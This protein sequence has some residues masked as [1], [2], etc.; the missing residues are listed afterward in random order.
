MTPVSSTVLESPVSTK[1]VK[2]RFAQRAASFSTQSFEKGSS[3]RV[4]RFMVFENQFSPESGESQVC[5]PRR[6]VYLSAM[7]TAAT[8]AEY[9]SRMRDRCLPGRQAVECGSAWSALTRQLPN[10]RKL[11]ERRVTHDR[12]RRAAILVRAPGRR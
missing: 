2:S 5:S 1:F 6:T 10:V 9:V 12:R 3:G 7:I 4:G 8:I 11:P